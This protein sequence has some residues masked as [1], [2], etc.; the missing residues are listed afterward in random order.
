MVRS[1]TRSLY[2]IDER[3]TTTEQV[4][5][6][7]LSFRTSDGRYELSR[8]LTPDERRRLS[9]RRNHLV[10]NLQ[11]AKV[12]EYQADVIQM[13]IGFGG[14]TTDAKE[15][16]GI[17]AQYATVLSGLPAW[18][19][20][21]ACQR[22]SMGQVTAE[23]IGA[24]T[25][26]FTHRPSAANVR[27]VAEGIVRP[28]VQEVARC[29]KTLN[30]TVPVPEQTPEE[31]AKTAARIRK[32]ADET[33]ARIDRADAKE[34]LAEQEARREADERAREA[35]EAR[36]RGEYAARGLT[37]PGGQLVS[38]AMLLKMGWT[39]ESDGKTNFLV[40]PGAA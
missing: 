26:S 28:F 12:S 3:D 17:A 36:L 11:A 21:R 29:N 14:A 5:S 31:R 37:P 22:W 24:K 19:V 20:R 6:A 34:A 27:V 7:V 16:A 13:L 32:L 8:H 23:E 18:A 38:L 25:V 15:A 39:I 30:S 9:A 35:H 4:V 33:I 2:P 1:S 40:R 10:D